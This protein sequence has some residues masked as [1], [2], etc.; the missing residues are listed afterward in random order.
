MPLDQE[1]YPYP[2]SKVATGYRWEKLGDA[3]FQGA[4]GS[5]ERLPI[6]YWSCLS[7]DPGCHGGEIGIKTS[8]EG[9]QKFAANIPSTIARKM[10]CLGRRCGAR[11]Q[12]L[13]NSGGLRARSMLVV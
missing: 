11:S 8:R 2:Q 12:Y 6:L 13:A 7:T 3:G 1:G 4:L 10:S 9:T 5:P